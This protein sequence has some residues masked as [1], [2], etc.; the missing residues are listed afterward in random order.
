MDGRSFGAVI[1]LGFSQGGLTRLVRRC[2]GVG[3]Q[4]QGQRRKVG[5]TVSM[6]FAKTGVQRIPVEDTYADDTIEDQ[7]FILS[8]SDLDGARGQVGGTQMDPPGEPD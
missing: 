2:P 3:D 1:D 7:G 4:G 6:K 5:D 8:L